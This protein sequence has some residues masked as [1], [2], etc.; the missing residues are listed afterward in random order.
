MLIHESGFIEKLDSWV[1]NK[2]R[3]YH[4]PFPVR[5]QLCTTWWLSLLYIII[6]P[7]AFTLLNIALCLVN[8]HLG[9]VTLGIWRTIKT[10]IMDL[11]GWIN[12]HL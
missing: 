9:E 5:C 3:F 2:W 4:L 8:A 12:K 11:L 7:G 1:N 6:T 10:A